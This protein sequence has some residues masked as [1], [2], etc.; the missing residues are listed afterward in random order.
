MMQVAPDQWPLQYEDL[1]LNKQHFY[2]MRKARF[3]KSAQS[4]QVPLHFPVL[5]DLLLGDLK[6][7]RSAI[8]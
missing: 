2:P 8:F 1:D 3:Q 5:N 6:E 4:Q 7:P